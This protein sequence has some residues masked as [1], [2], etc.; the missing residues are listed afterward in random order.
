MYRLN[1]VLI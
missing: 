1:Y